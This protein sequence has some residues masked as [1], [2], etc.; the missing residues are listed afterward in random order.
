MRDDISTT[1]WSIVFLNRRWILEEHTRRGFCELAS[2]QKSCMSRSIS[3]PRWPTMDE[4]CRCISVINTDSS[5]QIQLYWTDDCTSQQK[6]Q[7]STKIAQSLLILLCTTLSIFYDTS[8]RLDQLFCFETT[9]VPRFWDYKEKSSVFIKHEQGQSKARNSSDFSET[10]S[11]PLPLQQWPGLPFPFVRR[12]L[13]QRLWKQCL[14]HFT[15]KSWAGN[16]QNWKSREQWFRES[17]TR[18]SYLCRVFQQFWQQSEAPD[19]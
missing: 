18:K 14:E 7:H 6:L 9:D 19:P 1:F 17:W 3:V 13:D 12:K 4:S 2:N 15:N 5:A 16:W 8:Y 10:G 11:K